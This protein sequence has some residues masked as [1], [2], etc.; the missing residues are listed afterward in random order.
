MSTIST[1]VQH[2]TSNANH[3]RPTSLVNGDTSYRPTLQYP[4][5][6]AIGV[7]D[8]QEHLHP[9]HLHQNAY[10]SGTEEPNLESDIATRNHPAPSHSL[11]IVVA[12]SA[13][14]KFSHIWK[15]CTGWQDD[16]WWLEIISLILSTIFTSIIVIVLCKM[17]GQPM[18]AWKNGLSIDALLSILTGLSKA[19][20]L[21][22]I[23]EALGQIQWIWSS[24]EKNKRASEYETLE[25]ASRG[26][27]GAIAVLASTRGV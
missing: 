16:W 5:F 14:S 27:W 2:Y 18:A 8:H 7:R 13:P 24:K 17:D 15:W 3:D 12:Q 4:R 11:D 22:P 10:M 9:S 25:R 19:C 26:K 1:Q 6:D 23:S 21:M 20:L